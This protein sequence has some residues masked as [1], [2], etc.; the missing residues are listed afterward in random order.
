LKLMV[1][2]QRSGDLHTT[3]RTGI[4]VISILNR[5]AVFQGM[6]NSFCL[7]RVGTSRWVWKLMAH[8]GPMFGS[9]GSNDTLPVTSLLREPPFVFAAERLGDV[10]AAIGPLAFDEEASVFDFVKH[11]PK[12]L[13][14][15]TE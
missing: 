7:H 8:L 14:G 13:K 1:L 15:A 4:R 3:E 9:C 6:A 10:K 12:A 5:W 2:R 11:A